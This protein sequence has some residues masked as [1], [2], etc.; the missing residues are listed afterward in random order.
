MAPISGGIV[1]GLI[2]EFIFDTR[3]NKP[4]QE[5]VEEIEQGKLL[6]EKDATFSY[7]MMY[8]VHQ[9]MNYGNSDQN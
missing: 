9:T 8:H 6:P 5:F 3:R 2:Y 1:A 4:F 7:L